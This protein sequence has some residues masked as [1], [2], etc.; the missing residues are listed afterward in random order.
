MTL[1]DVAGLVKRYG[2]H[3]VVN[4]VSFQ[5]HEGEIVGELTFLDPRPPLVTVTAVTASL[6][7][8]L[9]HQAVAARLARGAARAGPRRP[10]TTRPR[11]TPAPR[12]GITH[13]AVDLTDAQACR[14]ALAQCPGVTHL[15]CAFGAGAVEPA[16]TRESLALF[17]HEVMPAFA[18]RG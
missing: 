18:T 6:V 13:L 12:P 11:R 8:E 17:A 4:D 1:L 2:A 16:V 14:T 3:T 7:L 9:P 5:V 10:P 15:L